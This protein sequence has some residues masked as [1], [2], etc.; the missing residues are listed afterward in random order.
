MDDSPAS[1]ITG[2]IVVA[3]DPENGKSNLSFH[4]LMI[5]DSNTTAIFMARGKHLHRIYQKYES[6]RQEMP[7]A[8]FIGVH[9]TCSLGALYTGSA[10]VE[11]Y[12]I[13]GGLRGSALPLAR[14]V[15]NDLNIPAEAEFALEGFVPPRERVEEGPFGEFTGYSSGTMLVPTFKVEAITSRRDPLYQD[16]LSGHAEHLLLPKLS[17][18]YDLLRIARDVAPTT[19]SVRLTLPLTA[20]LSLRKMDDD[21]PRRVIDA[22]LANDIYVKQVIVV[23]ADVDISDLRQVS[24]A[25]ALH[26]RPD[27]DVSIKPHVPLTELDPAGDPRDGLASKLGI[28]ATVKSCSSRRITKNQIPQHLLDSINLSEFVKAE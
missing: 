26:V 27:R 7:I 11:E 15:T 2:A 12:D 9:P 8:A 5:R 25:I 14:C 18:E 16:I 20:F 21:E 28:D 22:L 1:Y 17:M 23:D 3:R 10:D 24:T 6:Q 13:I 19:E 4:R